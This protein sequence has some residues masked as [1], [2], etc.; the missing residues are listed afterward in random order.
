MNP[1]NLTINLTYRLTPTTRS[2]KILSGEEAYP[3]MMKLKIFLRNLSKNV[4]NGNNRYVERKRE[5]TRS[6]FFYDHHNGIEESYLY[7]CVDTV[8]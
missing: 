6:I 2:I 5:L 7:Y 3:R 1:V 8:V 4:Y